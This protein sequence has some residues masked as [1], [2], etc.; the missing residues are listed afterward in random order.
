MTL[1]P[2]FY[3]GDGHIVQLVESVLRGSAVTLSTLPLLIVVAVA[4]LAMTVIRR[5]TT[6]HRLASAIFAVYLVGVA[7]FVILPL[8]FDPRAAE[9]AGPIDLLRLIELRP[10]FLSGGDVMPL[11]QGLLNILLTVPFGFGLP[12]VLRVPPA[13]VIRAGVLLSV[14]IEVTQLVADALYLALPTWSVDINDV[15]LNST[16][17]LVGYGVFLACS[18]IY[19]DTAGRLPIR[20]GPWAYFHDV[21]S[22]T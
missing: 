8:T 4:F 2:T 1:R 10:F 12:F 20:R 16:G 3:S 13:A 17:V 9:A 22:R 5:P 6:G 19:T 15:L 7:H 21:L 18:V 14:G 11:G